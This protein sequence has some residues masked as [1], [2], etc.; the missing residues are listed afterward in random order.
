VSPKTPSNPS[1]RP[2][3]AAPSEEVKAPPVVGAPRSLVLFAREAEP[4]LRALLDEKLAAASELPVDLSPAFTGLRDY[5]LR[6]GKR[7]RGALCGL[8]HEAA[9]GDK[10]D[11]LPAALGLELLHAYLLVHDDFMDRDEVRRGGPTM[12]VLLG[13]DGAL[14]SGGAKVPAGEHLGGCL[15]VLFGS[16]L[17]AWALELFFQSRVPAE[18]AVSAAK[19]LSKSLA[20]VT[21]GQALDLAAPLGPELQRE[22]VL[23]IERL[24]TGS[25]TFELPL[26]LGALLADAQEGTLAA[27]SAYARPLGQ[28]FQIADDLLGVFGSPAVTGKSAGNDLREG[29]RTLVVLR[30]LEVADGPDSAS[31]RAGLGRRDLDDQDVEALRMV[32]RRSGAEAWARGEAERLCQTALAALE[33]PALPQEIAAELGEIA[34]YAVLRVS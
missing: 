12:H 19:L 2:A 16:L 29:K 14:L 7:L 30:A 15:A 31:L 1:L 17:Q 10:A 11:V 20:E 3:A 26:L 5:V 21:L 23:T 8:G 9:G 32:L 6:G 18:R 24:K 28:A 22:G 34:R 4:R 13:R 27:L 33:T 25:Y